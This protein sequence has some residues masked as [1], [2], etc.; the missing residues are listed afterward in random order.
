MSVEAIPYLKRTHHI[1]KNEVTVEKSPDYIEELDPYGEVPIECE[2]LSP[3]IE[4]LR[5]F[6]IGDRDDKGWGKGRPSPEGIV[7]IHAT[8]DESGRNALI[9]EIRFPQPTI[10]ENE[11]L[12]SNVQR[13]CLYPNNI[14]TYRFLERVL[15]E[16]RD[17]DRK[18]VH[19][20]EETV[21]SQGF[22]GEI[23]IEMLKYARMVLEKT[24]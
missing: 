11:A 4:N 9:V 19:V 22:V 14:G 5:T 16:F 1:A 18:V 10:D 23:H 8:E 17:E 3:E 21:A 15:R 13:F 24:P 2:L 20:T 7:S 6:F 12:R